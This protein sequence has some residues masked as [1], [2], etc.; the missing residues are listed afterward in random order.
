VTD[1]IGFA[2]LPGG[3]AGVTPASG[4]WTLAIPADLPDERAA[5]AADFLAWLGEK[6]QQDTFAAEGGI[7][8]RRDVLAA[9]DVS[10]EAETYLTPYT[11]SLEQDLRPSIRYTFATAMLEV[12]EQTLAAITAGDVEPKAGMDS[13]QDDLAGIVREAGLLS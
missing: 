11:E 9:P 8:N 7:P 13:L 3:P 1:S 10:A 5:A 2:M 4:T 12:T 6:S